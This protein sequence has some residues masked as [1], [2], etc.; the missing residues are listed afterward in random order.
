MKKLKSKKPTLPQPDVEVPIGGFTVGTEFVVQTPTYFE[1]SSVV[2]IQN[3]CY[4][5][6]NGLVFDNK[7]RVTNSN[8]GYVIIPLNSDD[9]Q[10]AYLNHKVKW[11]LGEMAVQ[12][13]KVHLTLEDAKVVNKKLS[14]VQK[15]ISSSMEDRNLRK[16]GLKS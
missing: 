8:I 9:G 5:L 12:K 2:K 3:G 4:T 14:A 7:M 15:I 10:V 6:R 13:N 1:V 16:L 11:L